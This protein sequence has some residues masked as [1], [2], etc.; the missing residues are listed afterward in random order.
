MWTC[1]SPEHCHAGDPFQPVHQAACQLLLVAVDAGST[2]PTRPDQ[3]DRAAAAL[4]TLA[5]R[6]KYGR[7]TGK[8]GEGW[9]GLEDFALR[10]YPEAKPAARWAASQLCSWGL[11]FRAQPI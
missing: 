7:R 2:R 4:Q 1:V 10:H 9:A 5:K 8:P 11:Y 3:A 6:E